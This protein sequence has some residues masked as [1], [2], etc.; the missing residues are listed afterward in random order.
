MDT[1][2][3]TSTR[4]DVGRPCTVIISCTEIQRGENEMHLMIVNDT[5]LQLH[6]HD[7][8]LYIKE[9]AIPTFAPS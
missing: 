9:A 5:T 2:T 4:G 1:N 8:N 3:L 7:K 6:V